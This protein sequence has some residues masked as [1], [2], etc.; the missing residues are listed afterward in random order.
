MCRAEK[1]V[2]YSVGSVIDPCDIIWDSCD[3]KENGTV[4]WPDD[5]LTLCHTFPDGSASQAGLGSSY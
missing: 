4:R 5:F 1:P 2:A 3:G